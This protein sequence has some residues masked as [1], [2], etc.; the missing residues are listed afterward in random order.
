MKLK[1]GFENGGWKYDSN[2]FTNLDNAPDV[3]KALQSGKKPEF[4]ETPEFTP[5]GAMPATP[6]LCR[7]P[8]YKGG[9][10]LQSSGYETTVLMNGFEYDTVED[11]LDQQMILG[12][13]VKGKNEITLRMKAE[14]APEGQAPVV[15]IRVY[16][17]DADAPDKPGVEVLRWAASASGAPAEVTLPFTV[18]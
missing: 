17:L 15:Q 3:L 7:V 13:L 9:Y 10:K 8:D 6:P 5:P 2:R 18:N 1:F 16:K 4:L 12:G 11:A 14:P